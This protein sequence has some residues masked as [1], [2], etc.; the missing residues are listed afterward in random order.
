[1]ARAFGIIAA[2][3]VWCAAARNAGAQVQ[4]A[5]QYFDENCAACHTIGE[6]PFVGPDLK[7]VSDRK[8]RDWLVRFIEDPEAVIK[9]GDPDAKVLVDQFDGQIMPTLPGMTHETAE[10]LLDFINE[11]SKEGQPVTGGIQVTE[12]AFTADDIQRGRNLFYGAATFENGGPSCLACHRVGSSGGFGGG[13]LGPDL[14]EVYDRL[15]GRKGLG[16]WLSA[17]PLPTMK[18]LFAARTLTTEELEGLLAFFEDAAKGEAASAALSIPFLLSGLAGAILGLLLLAWTWRGRF[19]AVRRGL[20][21]AVTSG[22][23][24]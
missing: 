19:R 6:G 10:A 4:V 13:R 21:E 18:K 16:M 7:N 15:Q 9:S 1:M 5:S 8:D 12:R 14:T 11:K 17:P 22:G 24:R 20:V 3:I 23:A 2:G